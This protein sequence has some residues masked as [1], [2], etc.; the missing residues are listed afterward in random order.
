MHL[1]LFV[2]HSDM[3]YSSPSHAIDKTVKNKNAFDEKYSHSMILSPM[4]RS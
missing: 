3:F 1:D 2:K 4:V